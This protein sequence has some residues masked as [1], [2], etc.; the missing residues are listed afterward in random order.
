MY[1]PLQ[2]AL[3]GSGFKFPAHVGALM[4]IRDKGY[5]INKIAG[6][7]GGSIVAALLASGMSVEEMKD[8]AMTTDWSF[9]MSWSPLSTFKFSYCNGR[10]LHR[11]L[12]I[13]TECKTFE[14]CDIDLVIEASDILHESGIEFSYLT[15]PEMSVAD[16]VRAST[17]I[18]FVYEPFMYE[19][20]PLMDGGMAN[21]I[22]IDRLD[23]DMPRI[24]IQLVSNAA[25][26]ANL[27]SRVGHMINLMLS[28]QES[29]HVELGKLRG[30]TMAFIETSYA[31]SLDPNLSP[32]VRSRL[33]ADG[34]RKTIETLTQ[35]ENSK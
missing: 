29:T 24:G 18:P 17:S 23:L 27:L 2:V 16:A 15:T 35:M 26:G 7:S 33:I 34:Y 1:K 31:N 28:A 22:A 30:A 8:L 20:R 5:T 25:S 14:D 6:T 10:A 32:L 4:A 9:T 19:G 3:S 11:W 12:Q 13:A 21:N